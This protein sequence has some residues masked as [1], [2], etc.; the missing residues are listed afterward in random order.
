MSIRIVQLDPDNHDAIHQTATLLVAGF[1]QH[2]PNSWPD[3]ESALQEVHESLLDDR[4]SLVAL[5]QMGD[6]V[7]WIGGI[8]QYD[9]NVWELHPL[10]VHPDMHFKGIGRMLVD[11]FEREVHDQGAITIMLGTDDE[12]NMTT[13]AGVDLYPEPCRHI[14]RVSNLKGHPY[15]FYQKCGYVIV[16]VIPDANGYGKPDII[17]A[18]RVQQRSKQLD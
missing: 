6:I 11:R 15:E 16:G 1:K 17:M 3:L 2:W 14:D 5:D 10:V 18:K 7:G 12:D 9:G 4:I 8:K 13:L